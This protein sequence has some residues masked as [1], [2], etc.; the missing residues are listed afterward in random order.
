MFKHIQNLFIVQIFRPVETKISSN[1][2]E[3]V[4]NKIYT[5]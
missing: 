4:E 2:Y 1:Y 5:W 3:N